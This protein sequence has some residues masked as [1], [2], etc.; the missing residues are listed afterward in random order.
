MGGS[1]TTLSIVLKL[2]DEATSAMQSVGSRFESIGSSLTSTGRTLSAEVTLPLVGIG[3]AATKMASD[4]GQAATQLQ[5]EAGYSRDAMQGLSQSVLDFAQHGSQYTAF[6]LMHDGLYHIA[7]LGVPAANAMEVLKVATEGAAI[8]VAP[9]EDVANALGAAVASNIKGADNYKDSMA[10]LNATVGAGNMRM[11]DLAGSLGNVLPAAVTAGLTLRDIGAAMATMTDNGMRADEAST[12]LRHTL[13]MMAAPSGHAQKALASI[14]LTQFQLADDMRN[15]GLLPALQDLHEHLQNLTKDEQL[16]VLS[17]AFG[18]ARTGNA[19]Q[20]LLNNLDRVGQKYELIGR[21]VSDFDANYA[22]ESQTAAAKFAQAQAAMSAASIQLGAALLPLIQD[23]M[24][25]L[26]DVLTWVV[27]WF[28][29]LP[30]PVKDGILIFLG[31]LAALGPV[32]LV[33]GSLITIVGTLTSAFAADGVIVGTLIPLIAGLG[34]PLL[35]VIAATALLAYE[36]HKHWG[37]IV[38]WTSDLMLKV[39][40]IWNK[41][42]QAVSDFFGSVWTAIK[43]AVSEAVDYVAGLVTGLFTTVSNI[44][45]KI[46]GA[47]SSVGSA[48]SSVASGGVSIGATAIHAIVP[49]FASGGIVTGPTLALIGEAGPE[50]VVP[51]NRSGGFGTNIN[52]TITGNTISNQLDLRNLAQAVGDEIVR[53]LRLNQRLA[54]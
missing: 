11:A 51:L 35:I 36:V 22:T 2:I 25:K 23:V 32:L 50:A 54:I 15:K 37:S 40:T 47:I 14:G 46:M 29:K 27:N 17:G 12:N 1:S 19:I 6:Q 3:Y 39:A 9:L 8:G 38:D 44:I 28:T 52:V 26:V 18:G 24:P 48:I 42:W 53:S 45:S 4:F 5:T 21:Q 20:L 10:T 41:G 34:A 31:L 13:M 30:T 16:S 7:S 33:L 49:H 43:K